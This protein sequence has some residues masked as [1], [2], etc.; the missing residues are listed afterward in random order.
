MDGWQKCFSNTYKADYW[1]NVR[2]GA[3]SWEEPKEDT[4][5]VQKHEDNLSAIEKISAEPSILSGEEPKE[6]IDPIVEADI[7]DISM[8]PM[9]K[10][11][12]QEKK[13]RAP[14]KKKENVAS[15]KEMVAESLPHESV[16]LGNKK[17]SDINDISLQGVSDQEKKPR[18]P[19]KKKENVAST[20]EID[21]TTMVLGN[22][23]ESDINDISLQDMKVSDQEK[24]PRAPRKKK[25]IV[26]SA[27]EMVADAST[28]VKEESDIN[29]IS[30][31]GVSDQEKKPRKKKI[32]VASMKEMVADASP[33]T[34]SDAVDNTIAESVKDSVYV[35]PPL[36]PI[37]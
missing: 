7:K 21:A 27:K 18:A 3:K 4:T 34:A 17:E 6:V 22:K 25:I 23:E 30:Q 13:P 1:F 2:T 8:Q 37:F 16:T 19:R 26:A 28:M 15:T 5:S 32:I 12:D 24:K 33:T 14:R 36:A 20:K 31:Q 9:M 11:S 29:D 35:L 10:V